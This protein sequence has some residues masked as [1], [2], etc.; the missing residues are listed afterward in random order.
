MNF[1][2]ETKEEIDPTAD[3]GLMKLEGNIKE[4]VGKLINIFLAFFDW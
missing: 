3:E 4:K 1:K 2:E